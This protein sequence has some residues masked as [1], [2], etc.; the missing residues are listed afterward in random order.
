MSSSMLKLPL[1]QEVVR[2]EAGGESMLIIREGKTTW[3]HYHTCSVAPDAQVATSLVLSHASNATDLVV[4]NDA[5]HL[6]CNA[7]L[8]KMFLCK[9]SPPSISFLSEPPEGRQQKI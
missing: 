4:F 6:Q 9:T 5:M 8:N 3:V 1:V 7:L 2:H